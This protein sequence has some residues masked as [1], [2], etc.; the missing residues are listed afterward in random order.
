MN[1]RRGGFSLLEVLLALAIFLGSLAVLGELARVGMRNARLAGEVAEA[2]RLCAS[3]LAEIAV[4]AEPAEPVRDMPL[5][6]APG[7]LY[8]VEHEPTAHANLSAVRVI[9]RQDLPPER[10]PVEVAL[11]RWLRDDRGPSEA[12]PERADTADAPRAPTA[13]LPREEEP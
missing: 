5:S 8:T 2:E 13:V 12:V 11:V 10:R 7:W 4:G 1:R 9:V 3:K 6:S